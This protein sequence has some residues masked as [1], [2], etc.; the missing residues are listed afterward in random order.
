MPIHRLLPGAKQVLKAHDYAML[1][2]V[3]KDY[4]PNDLAEL[5]SDLPASEQVVV[6]R[7]LPRKKPWKLSN[8]SCRVR[9]NACC[10]RWRKMKPSVS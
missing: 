9:R 2:T 7:S 6:L 1:P 4:P 5:M 10:R 8:T 3:L